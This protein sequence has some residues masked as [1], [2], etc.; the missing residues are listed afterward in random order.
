MQTAL[1]DTGWHNYSLFCREDGLAFGYF[2]TD[3]ESFEEAC[4]RMD[5]LDVNR[6][7]QE[8][9]GKYTPANTSPIDHAKELRHFLYLGSDRVTS[10]GRPV[11]SSLAKPSTW[12]PQRYTGGGS[13]MKSGM[14]PVGFNLHFKPNNLAQVIRLHEYLDSG[15][16][17]GVSE[18][19]IENLSLFC[20]ED[21]LTFGYFE[22]VLDGLQHATQNLNQSEGVV[23]WQREMGRYTMDGKGPLDGGCEVLH[24][25]YL[26][27]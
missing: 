6:K 25:F 2:E 12:T 13:R 3:A 8:A 22:T 15:L 1:R 19:G 26:G 27:E 18:C 9:M 4:G 23:L 24:Y 10:R 20:R 17:A 16:V 14:K 7:W 11:T 21:G 5:A